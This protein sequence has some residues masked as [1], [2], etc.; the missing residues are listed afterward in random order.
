MTY[1]IDSEASLLVV[2][3]TGVI[4]QAE[5]VGALRAWLADPAFKP[6][7][8]AICDFTDANSTPTLS[9]LRELIALVQEHALEIGDTNVA[10]VTSRP[11]T[12][13]IAR[14]FEAL[15]DAENTPLHVK[16][17]FGLEAAWKWL[18]PGYVEP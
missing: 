13:G 2:R 12:F 7:L 9:D 4:T 6:G 8:D 15:A 10:V 16:V 3:G 11:I 1:R 18:R 5:R 14:V 17:F